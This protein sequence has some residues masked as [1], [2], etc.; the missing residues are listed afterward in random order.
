M[1]LRNGLHFTD[2][3]L[4]FSMEGMY[5]PEVNRMTALLKPRRTITIRINDE[6]I[7][8]ND[9]FYRSNDSVDVV[10]S[11]KTFMHLGQL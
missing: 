3:D 4:R 5:L 11:T 10:L 9:P 8:R 2:N 7:S 6:E 1:L